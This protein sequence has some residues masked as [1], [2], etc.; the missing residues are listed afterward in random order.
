VDGARISRLRSGPLGPYTPDAESGA[1]VGGDRH[2]ER[3]GSAEKRRPTGR[4]R[5]MNAL[6]VFAHPEPRAAMLEAYRAH[7]RT[8]DDRPPLF[9][10]PGS[11]FGPDKRLNPGVVA[12]S[13]F[14][15]NVAR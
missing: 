8:L 13:G 9:F 1:F 6:I 2:E 15:R 5:T 11:D 4:G 14:Q 3:V 12:R 7:L 10:H